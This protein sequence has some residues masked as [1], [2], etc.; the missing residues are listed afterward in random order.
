MQRSHSISNLM[1][2]RVV[3]KHGTVWIKTHWC[4]FVPARDRTS[5][6]VCTLLFLQ[7]RKC[8]GGA[9]DDI[10]RH[11]SD[12]CGWSKTDRQWGGRSIGEQGSFHVET[13]PLPAS[14]TV[15]VASVRRRRPL[16]IH[17]SCSSPFEAQNWTWHRIAY[18]S[19]IGLDRLFHFAAASRPVVVLDMDAGAILS[20]LFY[21]SNRLHSFQ[22]W[23]ECVWCNLLALPLFFIFTSRIERLYLSL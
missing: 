20:S 3:Q 2:R 22:C 1:L 4:W 16:P 21:L 8:V 7:R 14:T 23:A 18:S 17:R 5:S 6:H 9:F 12:W 11:N 15:G 13:E 19:N 10:Q